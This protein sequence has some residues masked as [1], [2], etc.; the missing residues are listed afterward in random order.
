MQAAAHLVCLPDVG[1][2]NADERLC[3]AQ[4][5]QWQQNC[6]G[7]SSPLHAQCTVMT[8]D[9]AILTDLLVDSVE[10]HAPLNARDINAQW[11]CPEQVRFE[12]EFHDEDGKWFRAHGNEVSLQ[13]LHAVVCT[14]DVHIQDWQAS[15]YWH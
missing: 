2:V 12:Y 4:D 7:L 1:S 14:L 11:W 8:T 13:S 10:M 6:S 9:S 5:I 3:C 15:W